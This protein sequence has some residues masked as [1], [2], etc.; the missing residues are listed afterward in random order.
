MRWCAGKARSVPVKT[1]SAR[2]ARPISRAVSPR[3]ASVATDSLAAR[4]HTVGR[5]RPQPVNRS[6][7]HRS[8]Q[9]VRNS[10][11]ASQGKNGHMRQPRGRRTRYLIRVARK[12]ESPLQDGLDVLFRRQ[13]LPQRRDRLVNVFSVDVLAL[14]Y[15]PPQLSVSNHFP[16]LLQQQSQRDKLA[17]DKLHLL[18]AAQQRSI[19]LEA[20]ICQMCKPTSFCPPASIQRFPS[21]PTLF[22]VSPRLPGR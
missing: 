6:L 16:P 13:P 4:V 8:S 10:E 9:I 20:G 22:R 17:L 14:P 18:F 2:M 3:R 19:R 5:L 1:M 11:L 15:R 12:A 7:G 21:L